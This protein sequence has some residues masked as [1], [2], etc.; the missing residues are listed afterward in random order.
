VTGRLP[1][2]GLA[3]VCECGEPR[4]AHGGYRRL[5]ACP[6]EAGLYA[7]RFRLRDEDRAEVRPA[8]T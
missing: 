8:S 6:G 5:G 7:R 2:P 4:E 1:D 3:A